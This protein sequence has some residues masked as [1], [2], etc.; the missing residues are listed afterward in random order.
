LTCPKAVGGVRRIGV[1]FRLREPVSGAC[2]GG[3][4]MLRI[5]LLISLFAAM[6]NVITAAAVCGFE[7]RSVQCSIVHVR[8]VITA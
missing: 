2:V 1:K 4:G 5:Y 8:F 6:S 3:G 7:E